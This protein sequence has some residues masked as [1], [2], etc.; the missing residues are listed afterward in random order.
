[1]KVAILGV[2][3][4]GAFHAKVLK[5]LPGVSEVRIND[6][7]ASRAASVAKELGA[8]RAATVDEALAGA[9]AAVIVTPTGTHAELIHRALDRR[10]PVFCEKPIA[11]DLESTKS[12]VEHVARVDGRV[13]IGFQRRFD[14]GFLEARR[15]VRAGEL[16]AVYGFQMTSCDALPPSDAYI[17]T[18]GGQFVDQLIHDFDMTR[19]IFGDEVEEL[20]ATGS[21]LGFPQYQEWEDV[22][23]SGVVV[24]L[25]GGIVGLLEGFRHNEAGYDI[26]VEIHGGKNSIAIGLDP[27][28]PL[29]S[30]ERD[31]PRLANPAYPT[32]F[33]RFADAYR[34]ELAHF[35]RFAEGKADNPCTVADGMEAL[36]IGLAARRSQHERRP[37]GLYEIA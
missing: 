27:R 24:R 13:Q 21:T 23:T 18:S 31:A 11:L 17:A 35:L 30:V 25:R 8:V 3:R 2:G 9:D 6:A 34:A 4:L 19:W 20:Y 7:D 32:F 1:V 37:V 14:A 5:E 12:V 36:R 22:A 33:V 10:L 16:G 15:R 28:T 26:H 29:V